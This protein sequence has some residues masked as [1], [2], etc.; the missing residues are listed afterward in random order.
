[1]IPADVVAEMAILGLSRDQAEKVA[2]MLARVERATEAKAAEAIEAR[3][4]NER[5]RTERYRSNGGG[6]I[7]YG[8]RQAVY[9][10]DGFACVYCGS[11]EY[12]QCDH[13]IPVS[14]GGET[15]FENLATACRV[16]NAKKR[17][18][19]RKAFVRSLSKEFH[20]QSKTNT[21][22]EDKKQAGTEIARA[23]V[24]PNPSLRSGLL[25]TPLPSVGPQAKRSSGSSLPADWSPPEELFTYGATLGLTRDQSS[26]IIE[27]MRLWAH[28]NKNRAVARK[29]DWIATMQG[30]LRRDA[31]KFIARAGPSR[32]DHRDGL[33]MAFR[34][35][36][37]RVRNNER[38]NKTGS[39]GDVLSLPVVP[40]KPRPNGFDV[41]GLL[42]GLKR[43]P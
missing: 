38:Q 25:V 22:T 27:R 32:N 29:A 37:E 26:E 20:G 18:R 30:A 7:D 35:T 12:L 14:K 28:G 19:D 42:D 34:E 24:N 3:R 23:P 6:S 2:E 39:A 9:E 5:G 10:R 31:P 11:S 36:M 1:M 40:E 33:A 13:V 41:G 16:C 21:T 43:F 15:S 4:E 8:L 17:D